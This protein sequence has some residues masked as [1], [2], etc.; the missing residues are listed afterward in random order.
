MHTPQG[1]L[2]LRLTIQGN[3]RETR[4]Y[5]LKLRLNWV[6]SSLRNGLAAPTHQYLGSEIHRTAQ[7]LAPWRHSWQPSIVVCA[8]NPVGNSALSARS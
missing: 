4:V 2:T 5:V 1:E 6:V 7:K 3:S 8:T